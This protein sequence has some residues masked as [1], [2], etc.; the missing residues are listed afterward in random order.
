[1]KNEKGFACSPC[2]FF[3]HNLRSP[4]HKCTAVQQWNCNYKTSQYTSQ[5][6]IIYMYIYSRHVSWFMFC[7]SACA[8]EG[9]CKQDSLKTRVK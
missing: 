2:I 4:H 7:A 8:V 6:P 9:I 1:M 5:H 3:L